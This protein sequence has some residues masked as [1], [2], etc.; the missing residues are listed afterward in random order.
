[1]TVDAPTSGGA[2]LQLSALRPIENMM[3]PRYRLCL[4]GKPQ[5]EEVDAIL[6]R[7]F[8][9]DRR[10]FIERWNF[11]ILTGESIKNSN[12]QTIVGRSPR[13][14]VKDKADGTP[15][16]SPKFCEHGSPTKKKDKENRCPECA[17]SSP[18]K[19]LK[20]MKEKSYVTKGRQ[21]HITGEYFF[22]QISLH[23]LK[24]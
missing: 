12:Q 19:S 10:R 5:I 24:S 13:K 9:A 21:A 20:M 8:D 17:S 2:G 22:I 3:A 6:A 11:D 14:D 23:Q 15:K 1:M 7:Q 16:K 18:R 4:F